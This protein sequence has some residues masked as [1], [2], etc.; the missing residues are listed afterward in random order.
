MN[1]E[2]KQKKI[3]KIA[4]EILQMSKNKLLVNMRFMDMS[5]N[6][7]APSPRPDITACTACDGELYV[8]NPVHILT[9]YRIEENVPVRNFLHSV[10]HCVFKHF[11]VNTL[12]NRELWDLSCDIA[13]ESA[14]N[15]LDLPF[16]NF[17]HLGEQILFFENF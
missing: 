1:E 12:I 16:L 3:E 10:F 6:K 13:V 2:E 8:Y 15:D 17:L 9:A 5:L 11:F 14:I 7:I 4:A